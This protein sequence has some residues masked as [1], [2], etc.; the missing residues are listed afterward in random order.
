[1]APPRT[2]D[3]E[4]L[5]ELIRAHPLWTNPQLA[6]ALTEHNGPGSR[7]VSPHVVA[8]TKNR[9][10]S[11]WEAEGITFPSLRGRSDLVAMLVQNTGTQIPDLLQDQIELRRLRQLDRIR[12]GL[13]VGGDKGERERAKAFERMLRRERKVIDLYPDGTVFLRSAAPWEIDDHNQLVSIVT[14]YRPPVGATPTR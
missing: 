10:K 6:E 12:L 4:K 3:L 1:M 14:A 8:A 5:K 7:P 2:F 9:L 11:Q 13:P